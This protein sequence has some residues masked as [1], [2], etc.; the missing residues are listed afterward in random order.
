VLTLLACGSL[1][2]LAAVNWAP[3]ARA[4]VWLVDLAIMTFAFVG[5]GMALLGMPLAA[6]VDDNNT[7]SISRLQM[8][9]LSILIVSAYL[10]ASM[11]N[12]LAALKAPAGAGVRSADPLLIEIPSSIW[13]LLGIHATSWV[14]SPLIL[15]TKKT[16]QA[17]P[18]KASNVLNGLNSEVSP[19]PTAVAQFSKA[20]QRQSALAS[21]RGEAPPPPAEPVVFTNAGN[22]VTET[23]RN[24]ASFA[25][26]F[27]GEEIGNAQSLDLSKVQLFF[28]TLIVAVVYAFSL[29]ASF[30]AEGPI[31]KFP[32]LDS[33]IIAL[34]GISNA[35]YLANKVVPHS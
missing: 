12:V 24:D 1:F 20:A 13:V 30:Q 2:V 26:L 34:L 27:R 19:S 14:G 25:D 17:D 11:S 4:T 9:I 21:S 23:H 22:V 28:F 35:G 31:R 18:V 7:Y 29:Y 5:L 32:D 3:P 16:Q 6:L 15:S 8:A 33:S 10:A